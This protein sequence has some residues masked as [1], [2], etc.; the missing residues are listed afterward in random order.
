MNNEFSK[1][2]KQ[3]RESRKMSQDEFANLLGTSKQVISRYE[4][5]QRTPKITTVYEYAQ[6][7]G[8]SLEQLTGYEAD[9]LV[10]AIEVK[11]EVFSIIGKWT[12]YQARMRLPLLKI[13]QDL[14]EE[15]LIEAVNY[16][17]YLQSKRG[18]Q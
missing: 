15:E 5:A 10:P 11:N 17:K 4:T 2:L 7:L 3:I 1:R 9:S 18:E 13:C 14:S 8:V 12:P 16:I 6:K